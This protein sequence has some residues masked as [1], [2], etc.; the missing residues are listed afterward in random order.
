[1]QD[2]DDAGVEIA[3]PAVRIV[4][5]AEIRVAQTHRHRVDRE[6]TS[7]QVLGQRRGLDLRERSRPFVALAA[8]RRKVRDHLRSGDRGGAEALVHAHLAAEALSNRPRKRQGVTLHGDVDV[9]RVRAAQQVAHRPSDQVGRGES[10]QRRQQLTH[11]GQRPDSLREVHGR[12]GMPAAVMDS[13]ASCT[14]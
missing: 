13:F 4:E 1:M 10:L 8:S 5:L 11:A 9:H 12:T 14:V 3:L 6:V 2:P 7:P